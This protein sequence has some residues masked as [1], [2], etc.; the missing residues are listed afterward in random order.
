MSHAFKSLIHIY[1]LLLRLDFAR[2]ASKF[3]TKTY[4]ATPGPG[5][6]QESRSPFCLPARVS[7]I[8]HPASS[9]DHSTVNLQ[10]SLSGKNLANNELSSYKC[11]DL[12]KPQDASAACNFFWTSRQFSAGVSS[13]IPSKNDVFAGHVFDICMI[14]VAT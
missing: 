4:G 3:N 5:R 2:N 12:A 13:H 1:V 11:R 10:S 9:C 7:G 8:P 6:C 14:I